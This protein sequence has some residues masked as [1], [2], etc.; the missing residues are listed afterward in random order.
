MTFS[1]EM[2]LFMGNAATGGGGFLN[3]AHEES[4]LLF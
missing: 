1:R 2:A 3:C 4:V